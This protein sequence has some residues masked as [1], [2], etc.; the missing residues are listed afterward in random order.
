MRSGMCAVLT[1]AHVDELGTA[2]SRAEQLLDAFGGD[3]GRQ[4][5][6]LR[7]IARIRAFDDVDAANDAI[8]RAL[9]LADE[10]G[11]PLLTAHTTVVAAA[12]RQRRGDPVD[13]E[14]MVGLVATL[15]DPPLTTRA[16]PLELLTWTDHVD[17]AMA[18]GWELLAEAE[19]IGSI[20]DMGAIR[21]QLADACFRAGRWDDA[22]ALVRATI[23]A[24]RLAMT[25]GPADCRPAD[26]AQTLA[27]QG[28]HEDATTLLAEAMV[29]DDLAPV[30]RLQRATRAGFV[31]LAAGDVSRAADHLREA[32]RIALAIGDG[33]LGA[34]PFRAD[35]V[36]VLVAIGA[37][38][39]AAEVA[40]ELRRLAD[41]GRLPRGA[42]EASRAAG[43]VAAARG[44]TGEA[45]A[46][47]EQAL[48]I[49]DRWP[50][51]FER[52]RTLLALGAV[53]RRS[54]RRAQAVGRLDA[55]AAVFQELGS[56][57]WLARVDAERARLG[58]R[59]GGGSDLT[60]TEQR[61]TQLAAQ[62]RTNAE[63]ATE[64]VVSLRT[65]ESNLTRA[66]RKLGVRS[67]TELAARIRVGD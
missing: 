56:A 31:T 19:A 33:D 46:W 8:D 52:G 20:D 25:R 5:R 57:P 39:E 51:P 62:G 36:E 54:G 37:L 21:D 67:R 65:V 3:P 41:R 17:E 53:L 55:A 4:A 64:L 38:D 7:T 40:A 66:Y 15:P 35:L 6:V 49:H 9:Q 2:L 12:I 58:T 14:A 27:A 47:L 22:A 29:R 30:I 24:D 34:M 48:E 44:A 13:V 59:R 18:L 60:P 42:A 50:V 1:L 23:E 10:S 43:L 28:R 63:I 32:R 45:T 26:L 61:V 11:D 16:L